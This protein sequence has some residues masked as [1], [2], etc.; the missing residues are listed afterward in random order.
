MIYGVVNSNLSIIY[1]IISTTKSWNWIKSS[2]IVSKASYDLESRGKPSKRV[3]RH[4]FTQT[5]HINAILNQKRENNASRL[6]NADRLTQQTRPV[7][8]YSER[9]TLWVESVYS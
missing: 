9:N 2:C 7:N 8:R 6:M 3:V 5:R 4:Q 1:P